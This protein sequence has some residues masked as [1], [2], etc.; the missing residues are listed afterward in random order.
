MAERIVSPNL[1]D[2]VEAIER[3]LASLNGLPLEGFES[4]W[5]SAGWSSAASKSFQKPAAAYPTT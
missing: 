5:E 4:S 2:I 1:M 3:I